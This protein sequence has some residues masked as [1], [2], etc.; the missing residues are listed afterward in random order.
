MIKFTI[1]EF[2]DYTQVIYVNGFW[3]GGCNDTNIELAIDIM[4]DAY[5]EDTGLWDDDEVEREV[6]ETLDAI[7]GVGKAELVKL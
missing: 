7:F 5:D 2:D 1:D 6:Q 3:C 4:D